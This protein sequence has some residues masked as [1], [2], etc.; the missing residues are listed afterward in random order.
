MQLTIFCKKILK[1]LYCCHEFS[2]VLYKRILWN[3]PRIVDQVVGSQNHIMILPN[4]IWTKLGSYDHN[5]FKILMGVG[6][7][8]VLDRGIERI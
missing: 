2:N 8:K 3:S 5:D 6:L 4:I 7:I 1:N